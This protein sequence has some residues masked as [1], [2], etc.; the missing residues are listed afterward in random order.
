MQ[1]AEEAK[2]NC[3]PYGEGARPALS[4]DLGKTKYRKIGN[5]GEL[6]EG[7]TAPSHR[8][9]TALPWHSPLWEGLSATLN[10]TEFL[11]SFSGV[12]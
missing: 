2:D 12:V 8:P 1:P 7:N 6:G 5:G 4:R 10:F 9:G 3:C 11:L